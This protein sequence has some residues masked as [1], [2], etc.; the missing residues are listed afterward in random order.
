MTFDSIIGAI[1]SSAN[2]AAKQFSDAMRGEYERG[3]AD[4]KRQAADELRARVVG[5][6]DLDPILSPTE[7]LAPAKLPLAS[8]SPQS[9]RARRGSVE[10]AVMGSIANSI[11]G[12]KAG[13]IA[14]ETGVPENSVRG[15]LNKLRKENRVFKSGEVWRPMAPV[16]Q[17]D[18]SF[19][20]VTP[21]GKL[22]STPAGS[23]GNGNPGSEEPG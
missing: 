4:G 6:L 23:A 7:I 19:V 21:E 8:S 14:A 22:V 13:E 17:S 18:G 10:P 9:H 5:V 15:M 12:K 3:V 2:E 20:Q 11:K 1:I 16:R